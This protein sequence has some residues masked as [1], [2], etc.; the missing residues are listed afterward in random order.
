MA[1]EYLEC[2]KC[3]TTHGVRGD[4]KVES[5]CDTP[6]VLSK[7]KT[8]Y[9]AKSGEYSPLKVEKATVH[10]GAVLVKLAGVNTV[11]EAEKFRN[12]VFYAHRNDI[13][14]GKNAV[15][16]A[17]MIGL[18]VIDV[19]TSLTLGKLSEVFEGGASQIYTVKTPGGK[20]VMIPAVPE[21]IKKIDT[22]SGIYISPIE[23]MFDEI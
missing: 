20:D 12:T 16:I 22:E 3:V 18:D 2:G 17:D 11:E 9:V 7:I 10:K 5:W 1:V 13:P 6:L 8:L 23:G 19:N 14:K 21:F 15:F 4:L